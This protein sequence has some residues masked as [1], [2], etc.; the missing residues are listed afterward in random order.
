MNFLDYVDLVRR[1]KW[2]VVFTFL[3]ILF[4]AS[5]YCVV[6]PEK[7]RSSTTILVVPQRVP[8]GYVRP[9]VSIRIEDR[10]A[11]IR[12]QVLSRTRLVAVMDEL[13]L[14]RE[15]R[16]KR[17][18]E[19]VVELMR[20]RIDIQVKGNDAFTLAF[21]HE[22]PQYA[23]LAASRLASL[24]IDE[25]L[26]T[27]EQQAVGTSEFLESQ[28]METK[29]R[30]EEQEQ[31]V[32]R[33]K[34]QFMGELPQQLE[35]N[36]RTLARL[37]D[38]MKA[39]AD[40][41]RGAE[42]RKLFLEAQVGALE[43]QAAAAQRALVTAPAGGRTAPAA[44]PLAALR[45][46]LVLKKA[47]LADL[48]ARYTER[49]PEVVKLRRDVADLERQVA[50]AAQSAA[51][52]AEEEAHAGSRPAAETAA[53]AVP[54]AES[55]EIRRL[56]A[57]IAV[58]DREIAALKKERGAIRAEMDAFQAKVER[59]PRREQE[60]IALTRD[61]DNL[62]RSYDELLKKKLDADVAQNLE[63][64]QKGEQFQILDPANLPEEPFEPNRK[65]VF[66]L[67]FLLAC[68]LGFGGVIGLEALD[69]TIKGPE[70]FRRFFAV[71]VLAAIPVLQ[72]KAYQRRVAISRALVLGGLVAF[73]TAVSVFLL[74][75]GQRIR[76]LV[77]G[78]WGIG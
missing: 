39:N 6:V 70:E 24:F 10:L 43:A 56:R 11:T 73:T 45:N 67:A 60:M 76:T 52:R 22:S 17:P 72:D 63:K 41:I 42:D 54:A 16:R 78:A 49:Y 68:A 44:D 32:R 65:K 28:L 40:A 5:V 37:Q 58:T 59:T 3:F 26:K 34:M 38:Q 57:Q 14:F 8:E 50:E 77:R 48:A 66:A 1:R 19:E 30:L 36:L 69:Q 46:E 12:Q 64:R 51:S 7:Y 31:R 71:P 25:N 18:L 35:T 55:A 29:K 20:K 74:V 27:R 33:Y 23:M 2:V 62:R 13:G 61:Y 47:R 15:E 53:P 75:Y 21:V 9:T 4:G